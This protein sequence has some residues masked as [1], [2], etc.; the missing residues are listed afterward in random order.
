MLYPLL[1][2]IFLFNARPMVNQN[3]TSSAESPSNAFT[4][5]FTR[6]SRIQFRNISA[7]GKIRWE[8]S[9]ARRSYATAGECC[10]LNGDAR[11]DGGRLSS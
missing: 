7:D 2:H 3:K 8:C 6:Q 10:L 1:F 5:C 9:K 11:P 4:T